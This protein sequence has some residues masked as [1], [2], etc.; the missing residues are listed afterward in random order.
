MKKKLVQNIK[1]IEAYA[2][3]LNSYAKKYPEEI[4]ISEL[5]P[6]TPKKMMLYAQLQVFIFQEETIG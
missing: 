4:L 1:I 5:F 3:G 2:D 6:I